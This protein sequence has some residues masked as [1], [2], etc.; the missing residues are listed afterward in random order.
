MRILIVGALL[1]AYGLLAV[2]SVSIHES[3]TLTL[4]IFEDPTN[5]FYFFRHLRNIAIAIIMALIAYRIPIKF[6]KKHKNIVI[7][8][9]LIFLLQLLVFVPGI[10]ISL[11]GARGW[12]DIPGI[13]SI[14]PSEFFKLGYVIFMAAWLIRKKKSIDNDNQFIISFVVINALFLFIF[15]LIPDLGSVLV[16][17][18]V[19]LTMALY[20][21]MD[22]KKI[23][24][25]LFA[26][27]AGVVVVGSIAG[28]MNDR[29]AYIQKRMTY[30][31]SSNTD[32]ESRGIGRQ[33]EQALTA[34]GGGGFMG[35]GYGKGLQKF[36]YI[37]EAQSDFIFAAFSE[38]MGFF[39]NIILL[40]LYFYLV[41]YV[42]IK[43]VHVR[44]EYNKMLAIGILSLIII[45]AF[46]NM[47]VN[48]KILPNTGLTLPFI[49]HGGSALMVNMIELILLYKI[50]ENK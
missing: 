12:I 23:V 16:M 5:Y 33:N 15:L 21:G 32:E 14:Q 1:I 31:I 36:G 45:Q 44:D 25:L 29:F 9:I 11:N 34:I 49:S 19:G 50:I 17:G 47:G 39:G 7:I 41:Y 22:W 48:L 6:F 35:K 38:E 13:P 24:G 46:I 37:P 18:A 3:F 27:V 4:K 30:F 40:G 43:L 10:G 26:G 28:M 8:S 20:A 2:Y 42:L